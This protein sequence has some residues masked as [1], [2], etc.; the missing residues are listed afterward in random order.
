VPGCQEIDGTAGTER[1][2]RLTAGVRTGPDADNV[3][4]SL[5]GRMHRPLDRPGPHLR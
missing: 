5:A 2:T 4:G 1:D 3:C